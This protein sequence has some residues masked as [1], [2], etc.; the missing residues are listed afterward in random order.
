MLLLP[1]DIAARGDIASCLQ[2]WRGSPWR[3]TPRCARGAGRGGEV[4]RGEALSFHSA[5]VSPSLSCRC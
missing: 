1:G 3:S 2:P 5:P 4:K